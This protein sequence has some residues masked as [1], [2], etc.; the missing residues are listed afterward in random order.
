MAN[1]PGDVLG[2]RSRRV[3]TLEIPL[4][5]KGY[6]VEFCQY[7]GHIMGEKLKETLCR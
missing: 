2:E 5:S 3:Y 6:D 1:Y 4:V 7:F